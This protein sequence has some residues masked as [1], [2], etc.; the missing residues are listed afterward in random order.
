MCLIL[1]IRYE[2][3]FG[4][5]LIYDLK[6][7][8][9]KNSR[10]W[11]DLWCLQVDAAVAAAKNAFPQWSACS[12]QQRAD[13]LN[14]LADLIEADMEEFVQAESRDQGVLFC[15]ISG[16]KAKQ[17]CSLKTTALHGQTVS[18]SLPSFTINK[19][20]FNKKNVKF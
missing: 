2:V 1:I 11:V 3:C 14:K 13:V 19:Y 17:K 5:K 9:K 6:K 10:T 12:P 20:I 16:V 15:S 7:K 4:Q 8:K 18:I